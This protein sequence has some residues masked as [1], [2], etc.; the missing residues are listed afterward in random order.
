MTQTLLF[1]SRVL[2]DYVI[3]MV[4]KM[5]LQFRMVAERVHRLRSEHHQGPLP[6]LLHEV[7]QQAEQGLLLGYNLVL[8]ALL[9]KPTFL[10]PTCVSTT[11]RSTSTRCI[12][13]IN[14]SATPKQQPHRRDLPS[15]FKGNK[16]DQTL[17]PTTTFKNWTSEVQIYMSLEDHNLSTH[18]DNVKTQTETVL[19]AD[20]SYIIAYIDHGLHNQGLGQ[21]KRRSTTTTRSMLGERGVAADEPYHELQKYQTHSNHSHQNRGKLLAITQKPATT[22]AKRSPTQPTLRQQPGTTQQE[23]RYKPQ[24]Q[25]SLDAPQRTPKFPTFPKPTER[26]VQPP[27]GLQQ[28]ELTTTPLQPIL[29]LQPTTETTIEPKPQ[30]PRVQVQPTPQQPQVRRRITTK[31]TPS[32]NDLLATIAIGVLHLS[33]NEDAEEKKLTTNNMILQEWHDN[34]NEDYDAYELKA[35]IKQEHDAL[36]KTQVFT[37]VNAQNYPQQQ[38]KDVIQ[39][40]WVI[41]SR[42]GGKTKRRKARFVAK[43]F[44]QKV[45]INEIY[46]AT[47]AA[48]TLRILLTLAQLKNHSIYMS[49]IQSA[50]LNTPVQPGTTILVKTPAPECEQDNNILWKLNKQLYGLRDSPQKFQLHLSSILKQL[51]LRQLRSDQ[52]VYHDD[53]ITVMVDVDDLLLIGEDDKIKTFLQK[54]ESQLQLKHITVP[55]KMTTDRLK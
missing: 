43:G 23:W 21:K 7:Q 1:Y 33:T 35:A 34:D 16:Q 39:T 53:D 46:A 22:T 4:Y 38:L 47:P 36:Q 51:G 20:A 27:P 28:P 37:K 18:M 2:A 52:C 29:P 32:K 19:I 12:S 8:S 41:R 31:T 55:A 40:E 54:L 25:T 6:E 5:T 48:I 30:T 13:D 14:M 9:V 15:V 44:T 17:G 11:T 24:A 3:H 10:D 50:F 49:D 45:N 26:I 42:P